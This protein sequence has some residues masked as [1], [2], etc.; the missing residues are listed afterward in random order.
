MS[1]MRWNPESNLSTFPGD[2]L[3]IQRGINR[4]FGNF[5]RE[6]MWDEEMIPS[7]WNPAVD[8]AEKDAEYVIMVELPGV[9]KDAVKIST[10]DN[11]LTIRGEKKEEKESK[12]SK[13]H[14]VERAY[15]SFQRS[16]TLPTTVKS[17]KIEASFNDG[18]LTIAL[19][20][21]EQAK[22]KMIEVTIR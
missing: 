9:A 13:Y 18:M 2:I 7:T 1:I 16:F 19:P 17:D 12:G 5:F 4:M 15:G 11:L 22:P 8:I 20:K 3:G 14:R 10:V 6:G 21:A